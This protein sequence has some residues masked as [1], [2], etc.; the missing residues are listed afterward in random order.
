[1]VIRGFLVI[2]LL[3]ILHDLGFHGLLHL[4]LRCRLRNPCG[5]TFVEVWYRNSLQLLNAN[6]QVDYALARLQILMI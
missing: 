1:M 4:L 2:Q 5:F 6:Q 3:F